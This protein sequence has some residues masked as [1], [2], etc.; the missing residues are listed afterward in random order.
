MID[1]TNTECTEC[2]TGIY[3]ETRQFDDM[4]GVIHCVECDHEISRWSSNEDVPKIV[5]DMYNLL[6]DGS[7]ATVM[8]KAHINMKSFKDA[9][10]LLEKNQSV[11]SVNL[12]NGWSVE[13]YVK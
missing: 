13:R 5:T 6:L 3:K 11:V 1:R 7:V 4:D 9:A 8:D 12:I 2:E 10:E